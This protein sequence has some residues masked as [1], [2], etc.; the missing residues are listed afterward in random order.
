MGLLEMGDEIHV[1]DEKGCLGDSVHFY[2]F[3]FWFW[4]LSQEGPLTF[5]S[6]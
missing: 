3:D 4:V 6:L 5:F 1:G 2:D